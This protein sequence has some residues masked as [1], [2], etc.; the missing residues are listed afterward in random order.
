MNGL[1]V[2]FLNVIHWIDGFLYCNWGKLQNT[3]SLRVFKE[4]LKRFILQIGWQSGLT[5]LLDDVHRMNCNLRRKFWWNLSTWAVQLRD[6]WWFSGS[7]HCQSWKAS[8]NDFYLVFPRAIW[9][10]MCFEENR[11]YKQWV[12]WQLSKIKAWDIFVFICVSDFLKC[13]LK[14]FLSYF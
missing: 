13:G 4:K 9:K 7:E 10:E 8:F 14:Y 12:T 3:K 5:S 2:I 1:G 6:I 11:E